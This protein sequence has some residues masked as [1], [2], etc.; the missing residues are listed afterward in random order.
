[1]GDKKKEERKWG[2]GEIM[3]NI[4]MLQGSN[5]VEKKQGKEKM[6]KAKNIEHENVFF[7][8]K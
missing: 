6:H 8:I 7:Y 1:M 3:R 4:F 5:N 2:S